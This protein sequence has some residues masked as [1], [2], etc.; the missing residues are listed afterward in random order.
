[1]LKPEF[2]LALVSVENIGPK[3]VKLLLDRFG[4]IE[5]VFLSDI[6]D[7]ASLP[8][9]NPL[10]AKRIL[11]AGDNLHKFKRQLE[12]L[13]EE[14]IKLL[15]LN[16]THYPELLK[17]IPNPP[18]V[19]CQKGTMDLVPEKSVAI[20]GT[21]TPTDQGILTAVEISAEIA[22]AGFTIVSGLAKGID[23]AAHFGALEANGTTIGVLGCSLWTVYPKENRH[24][25][26]RICDNG[27]LLSEHPFPAEPTSAN[28][29]SR[30]RIISGLSIC[31]IVIETEVDGGAIRTAQFAQKQGR[32][33]YVYNWQEGHPLGSGNE[34]LIANGA[35]GISSS[36]LPN[37]MAK[38][39]KQE[40]VGRFQK[41]QMELF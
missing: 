17:R 24:L 12:F 26:S 8:K 35:K 28:L 21:R 3:R 22:S 33:C 5:Q 31:V 38:L 7:I 27:T 32:K 39:K 20:V 29:I 4:T 2:W 23:T 41:D 9:F 10:L 13:K 30:N 40:V 11:Q 14:G 18:P 34:W 15:C 37:L 19:L 16:D 25:A 1:M 36:E 6:A